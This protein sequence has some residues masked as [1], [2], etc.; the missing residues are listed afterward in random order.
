MKYKL[1]ILSRWLKTDIINLVS[2][3]KAGSGG[4][5]ILDPDLVKRSGP[6]R[7]RILILATLSLEIF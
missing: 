7:I 4:E 2:I 6:D 1:I 5:N 3:L